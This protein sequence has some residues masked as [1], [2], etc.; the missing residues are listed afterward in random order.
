MISEAI[1]LAGGFGTRLREVV[2]DVPKP[3][4]LVN[5]RP[6]LYYLFRYLREFDIRRVV[7]STGYMAE[8][9]PAYFGHS[10]EEMELVYV[11]EE[12]PL[13]TGGGIRLALQQCAGPTVLVLNGDSFLDVDLFSFAEKHHELRAAASLAVREV[14]DGSRY[15]TLSIENDRITAFREKSPETKG[16]ASINGGVYLLERELFLEK[17][18][19]EKPF[20]I[21]NDFFAP[22]CSDLFFTAFGSSGYFIDIG[23]PEDYFRAQHEFASFRY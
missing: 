15:G 1:V 19:G 13:G 23:V 14:E 3:M 12:T 9:I 18:P 17:T 21:E 22:H 6:F 16:A 7:L 4:A 2:S 10:F 5:G 20:S 11:K 8:T